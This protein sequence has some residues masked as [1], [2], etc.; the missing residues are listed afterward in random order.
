MVQT[1]QSPPVVRFTLPATAD[2]GAA[3]RYLWSISQLPSGDSVVLQQPEGTA[4]VW[5]TI[6]T[7]HAASGS[8][9]LSALPLGKAYTYRVAIVDTVGKVLSSQQA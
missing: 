6:A 2:A 9:S 8:A 1:P 5:Q 4:K 7:Q 3:I